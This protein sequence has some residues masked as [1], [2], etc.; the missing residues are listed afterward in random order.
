[1]AKIERLNERN[2]KYLSQRGRKKGRKKG[3]ENCRS[4]APPE[5]E[6][7]THYILYIRF[8]Y[9]IECNLSNLTL[10]RPCPFCVKSD[11]ARVIFF[12]S[13]TRM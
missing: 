4:R 12:I 7:K 13:V 9:S 5:E 2:S 1:M 6:L 8:H 3:R 10:A 11:Y